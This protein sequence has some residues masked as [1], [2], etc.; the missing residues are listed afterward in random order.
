MQCCCQGHE[1]QG[2]GQGRGL[3]NWSSRIRLEYKN[4][5]REKQHCCEAVRWDRHEL[6]PDRGTMT[7]KSPIRHSVTARRWCLIFRMIRLSLAYLI[8]ENFRGLV[9]PKTRTRTSTWKFVLEDPRGQGLS[10]RTTTLIICDVHVYHWGLTYMEALGGPIKSC[11]LHTGT[12]RAANVHCNS[13]VIRHIQTHLTLS[14][15]ND[16]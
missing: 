16:K 5:S 15:N 12:E 4:F 2:R 13:N 8:L 3:E 11:R 6:E 10:L 7:N 9:L 1:T 14:F